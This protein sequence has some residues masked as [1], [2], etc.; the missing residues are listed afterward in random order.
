MHQMG[1]IAK[2]GS[3]FVQLTPA[4]NEYTIGTDYQNVSDFIIGEE[5]LKWSESED[6]IEYPLHHVCAEIL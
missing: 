5:R 6:V 3:A 1:V 2:L 4:L